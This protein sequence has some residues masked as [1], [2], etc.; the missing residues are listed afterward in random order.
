MKDKIKGNRR[1]LTED[2]LPTFIAK[3]IEELPWEDAPAIFTHCGYT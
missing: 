2:N 1:L 3:A